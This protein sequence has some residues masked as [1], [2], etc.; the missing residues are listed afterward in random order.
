VVFDVKDGLPVD[1]V[2]HCIAM[3]LTYHLRKPR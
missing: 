2:S 3:A 1:A